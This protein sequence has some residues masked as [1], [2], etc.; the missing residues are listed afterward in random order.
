P[1]LSGLLA[2]ATLAAADPDPSAAPAA[3]LP[4]PT[5]PTSAGVAKLGSGAAPAGTVAP[6]SASPASSG[7]T[8]TPATSG[9]VTKVPSVEEPLPEVDIEAPEPKYVAPTL[10][11]RIGRIWAPV[12]IDGKGPFRLVLDTGANHSAVT[13]GVAEALGMQL[14]GPDV[15][16]VRLH[17]VMGTLT[18]PTIHVANLIVGDLQIDSTMLPIVPDALGG[19]QGVLGTEGLLDKRIFIDFR[20][21]LITI[22]RSHNRRADYGYVTVPVKILSDHLLAT[23]AYIGTIK[24]TAIIDTGAQTSIANLALREAL[25]ARRKHYEFSK[26]QIIDTTD[27]VAQ[28]QG[29]NVAPIRLGDITIH[30]AHLTI[31][32]VGIFEAW[33]LSDSPALLIGMDALGTVDVLVIDYRRSELQILARGGGS[34]D[35]SG[36]SHF[37]HPFG[38]F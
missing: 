11:D 7:A 5:A 37:D 19:A 22:K 21:D 13:A 28:G 18:V 34:A 31:G 12:L 2:F 36:G 30:S 15:H 35:W 10:R 23:T 20:H 27:T 29:A 16:V 24:A 6:G 25:L 4:Q 38:R 9:G 14:G 26:D 8:G 3:S 1:I 32:D 17:G 33:K